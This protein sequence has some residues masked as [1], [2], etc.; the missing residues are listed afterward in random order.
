MLLVDIKREGEKYRKQKG[1]YK[2][3][4]GSTALHR[5]TKMMLHTRMLPHLQHI[6]LNN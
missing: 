1:N 4:A 5:K 2:P 6:P 3:V